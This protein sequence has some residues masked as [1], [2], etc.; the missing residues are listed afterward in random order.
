M[1]RKQQVEKPN[2][3]HQ[4]N[5]M[6]GF[7]QAAFTALVAIGLATQA[8]LVKAEDK[9]EK[10]YG[11]AK[12]GMNDCG[13]NNHSCQ[14]QSTKNSDPSEWIFLPAGT[15]NK[16]VGGSLTSGKGDSKSDAKSE[17]KAETKAKP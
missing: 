2:T 17:V 11:I 16:I 8:P 1:S 14:G 9:V 10:C 5:K 4:T 7:A 6:K 3:S 12:K 13:A 15:C